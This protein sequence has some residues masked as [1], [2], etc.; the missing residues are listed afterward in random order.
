MNAVTAVGI[1]KKVV[2]TDVSGCITLWCEV[3]DDF[4]NFSIFVK[5]QVECFY[6]GIYSGFANFSIFAKFINNTGI[7]SLDV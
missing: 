3:F 6:Q 5:F 7:A 2:F 1:P 4:A